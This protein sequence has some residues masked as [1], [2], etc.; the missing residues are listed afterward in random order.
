[1]LLGTSWRISWEHD[2]NTLRTR[3]G[4]SLNLTPKRK[5]LGPSRVH[6][7][8]FHWLHQTSI[9]KTI[10][11]HFW[12]GLMAGHKMWEKCP[13]QLPYSL[14]EV[15]PKFFFFLATN[16]SLKKKWNLEAPPKCKVLFWSTEFPLLAQLYRWKED[17]VC[18]SIRD[19]SEV[20]SR[21]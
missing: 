18:Q 9:F 14:D 15:P 21:T 20:A 4:N 6:P 2:E 12:V 5:K 3:G 17:N 16:P 11:H 19:K 10:C 7:E 1:M 8:R 13:I